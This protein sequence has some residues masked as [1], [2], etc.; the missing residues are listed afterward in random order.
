MK[1]KPVIILG[2][3]GHSKVLIDLLKYYNITIIGIQ[4]LIQAYMVR[5]SWECR[6]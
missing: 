5:A 2:A 1:S 3:G 4:I 6:L